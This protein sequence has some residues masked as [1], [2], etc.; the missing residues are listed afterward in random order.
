ML[1]SQQAII[2]LLTIITLTLSFSSQKNP[3]FSATNVAPALDQPGYQ[4]ALAPT[5]VGGRNANM[6]EYPW[7]VLLSQ[8]CG[9]SL[10]AAQWVLTAAHCV[11]ENNQIVDNFTIYLGAYDLTN[12]DAEVQIQNP[13]QVIPHPNY[14][15]TTEN[16]DLALI[17]LAS[18]A[19]L[20]NRVAMIG[21]TSSDEDSSLA[22][23]GTL[24]TVTGWGTLSENG[25]SPQILQTVAVPIVANQTCNTTYLGSITNNMLCA[26]YAAGG[27]DACQ[28]DSGGPLI[29]ADGHG[30]WKQTGI[31]SFGIGCAEPDYYGVYTR[32]SRYID[33]ISAQISEPGSTPT[34]TPVTPTVT[35][36]PTATPTGVPVSLVLSAESGI[37]AIFL[38]WHPAASIDVLGYQVLRQTAAAPA[39][40]LTDQRVDTDYTDEAATVGNQLTP[41]V[42]YCY[43]VEALDEHSKVV[44]RSNLVCT[45]FGTLN[46]AA[47]NAKVKPGTIAA[48]PITV[49]NATNL[50]LSQSHIVLNYDN[51]L[52][53]YHAVTSTVL[54]LGYTWTV[55][56]TAGQLQ[57]QALPFSPTDPAALYGDGALFALSFNAIGQA[58]EQSLLDLQAQAA[59]SQTG[60]TITALN[61]ADQVVDVPLSLQGGVVRLEAKP[62]YFRGDV[63]GDGVLSAADVDRTQQWVNS[64]QS[65]SSTVLDADVLDAD[66]LDA[67]D[68]NNNG[69]LD[70]GDAAMIAY[71]VEN[72]MW[73]PLPSAT[74][75]ARTNAAE[76]VN[77]QLQLD[78][79]VSAMASVVVTTTLQ[80]DNATGMAAG[81]F[82]LVYDPAVIARIV[83][84]HSAINRAQ[85]A[86]NDQQ[87]GLLPMTIIT[88][89]PLSGQ[90]T[91]L[92]IVFQLRADAPIGDSP[93]LLA[94]A[95]LYDLNGRD[96]VR[97]FANHALTRQSTTI[98]VQPSIKTLYLPVIRR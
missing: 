36:A 46:I 52:L 74:A 31:V 12:L 6:G 15:A 61:P 2:R 33:W 76:P 44:A 71:V 20:N 55:T 50:R 19:T 58:G 83:S 45:V 5:I 34:P 73:P 7:Q 94:D 96:L 23:A 66:V 81:E 95:T 90:Q 84:V 24:A 39:I 93:L 59:I 77:T 17:K 85:T 29:V 11:L 42:E 32:V 67:G 68:V 47:T 35:P 1:N 48:I 60:S 70:A 87:T 21:L 30:H 78:A 18:P 41:G 9:G 53:S 69:Q 89:T 98:H 37:A 80:V 40:I 97:S 27:K 88:T 4:R 63:N 56:N 62:T 8:G 25:P 13:I 65:P 14:N 54:T 28:G 64:A 3:V 91:L 79:G 72:G 22:S 57:I 51:S 86:F 26:G 49:H 82:T 75:N 92:T 43:T 38:D 16:N 10:I